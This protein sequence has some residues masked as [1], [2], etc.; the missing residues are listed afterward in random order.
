MPIF[1]SQRLLQALC[2]LWRGAEVEIRIRCYLVQFKNLRVV[3]ITLIS[4]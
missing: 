4:C 2:D 3:T 1:L